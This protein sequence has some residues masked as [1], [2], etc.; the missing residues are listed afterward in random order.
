M[1]AY[2]LG[3]KRMVDKFAN[4]IVRECPELDFEDLRGDLWI[5][6]LETLKRWKPGRDKGKFSTYLFQKLVWKSIDIKEKCISRGRLGRSSLFFS[7]FSVEEYEEVGDSE[8]DRIWFSHK[9]DI[10][11]K[12]TVLNISKYENTQHIS[13]NP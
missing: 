12:N 6:A 13:R 9:H 1:I 10:W 7:E 8:E 11:Y 2:L 5:V 3:C 4:S